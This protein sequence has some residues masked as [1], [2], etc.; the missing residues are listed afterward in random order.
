MTYYSTADYK[1]TGQLFKILAG[2]GLLSLGGGAT[3]GGLKAYQSRFMEATAP[4]WLRPSKLVKNRGKDKKISIESDW[5]AGSN[6]AKTAQ[7][8]GAALRGSFQKK[9][10]VGSAI[11][12]ATGKAL[13]A[14]AGPAK[15]ERT[16]GDYWGGRDEITP[17]QERALNRRGIEI[18]TLEKL[19][20]SNSTSFQRL[21]ASLS[22]APAMRAAWFLPAATAAVLGGGYLGYRGI[23]YLDSLLGRSK[24]KMDYSE[25][26]RQIYEESAKYLRDTAEGKIGKRRQKVKEAFYKQAD[27]KVSGDGSSSFW[28][29]GA[30]AI[31]IPASLFVARQMRNFG[32]GIESAKDELADRTHMVRAWQA[33]AKERQYDYNNFDVELDDE[34]APNARAKKIQKQQNQLLQDTAKDDDNNNQ[35]RYENYVFNKIRS[36]RDNLT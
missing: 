23:K 4:D 6:N 33:A 30:L 2:L 26:A 9:A 8:L 22:T 12:T 27:P 24:H 36:D 20:P 21:K 19:N 25:R 11:A 31:G 34:A 13:L 29:L 35:L 28:N 1:N 10:T 7:Y 16:W 5:F 18:R 3:Y 17:A 32:A 14:A 15:Y